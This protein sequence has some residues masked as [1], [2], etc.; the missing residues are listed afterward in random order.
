M[1][2]VLAGT[3]ALACA[4][5]TSPATAAEL[6]LGVVVAGIALVL[7]T[8]LM[9]GW[10]ARRIR[11]PMVIG[12]IFAGIA[13]GP[14]VL[15]FLPGHLTDKL[16]PASA[17]PLLSAV[18]G[19]GRISLEVRARHYLGQNETVQECTCRPNSPFTLHNV[20]VNRRSSTPVTVELLV[21]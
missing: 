17:R 6:R 11:Q 20:R 15:G 4:M 19:A 10:L 13:L 2:F 5:M 18:S 7:V 14:S 3:A 16:F 12:E 9:F 21:A 8:G 1:R